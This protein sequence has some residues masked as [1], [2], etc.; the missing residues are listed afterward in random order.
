M[1]LT[2]FLG[3]G[4]GG[5]NPSSKMPLKWTKQALFPGGREIHGKEKED[6]EKC[7]ALPLAVV[8][9]LIARSVGWGVFF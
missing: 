1:L 9:R 8:K 7:L 4:G 2:A 6:I 3:R 5:R